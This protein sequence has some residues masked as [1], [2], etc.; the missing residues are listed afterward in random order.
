MTMKR[1][2]LLMAT[3]ALSLASSVA[4]AADPDAAAVAE[5]KVL[6]A[7][8]TKLMDAGDYEHAIAKFKAA[9]ALANSPSVQWN[10]G[11]CEFRAGRYMEAVRDLRKYLHDPLAKPAHVQQA[12]EKYIPQALSHVGDVLVTADSGAHVVVDGKDDLGFAPLADPVAVAAGRHHIEARVG[13]DVL[14]SDIEIAAGQSVKVSLLAPPASALAPWVAPAPG[15][16]VAPQAPSVAPTKDETSASDSQ[17]PAP[18]RIWMTVGFGV[19]AA[20]SLTGGIVFGAEAT[21]A[22]NSAQTT[23]NALG[24]CA[25]TAAPS[26]CGD[27]KNYLD[28]QNRD[29]TLSYV[30]YAGAGAFAAGALISWFFLPKTE[31]THSALAP[32]L[33]PGVAGARWVTTF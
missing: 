15:D 6:F 20:A 2:A 11:F 29:Q 17:K 7:D 25:G 1:S 31:G 21:S 18:L 16:G 19:A 10:L 22:K 33:A 28:T 23:R 30:F 26:G 9:N 8:G 14:V 32:M 12:T 3:F 27:L 4:L 13:A 24:S 5:V